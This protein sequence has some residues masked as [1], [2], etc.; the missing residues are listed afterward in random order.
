MANMRG[1]RRSRRHITEDPDDSDDEFWE[2]DQA[3]MA[4][5]D[6]KA[7]VENIKLQQNSCQK[8]SIV[9]HS[10]GTMN[11]LTAL[12]K[13]EYAQDYLAQVVLMEPCVVA[14]FDA[15]APLNFLSY[16]AVSNLLRA[17]NIESLFRPD[18]PA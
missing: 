3:E 2:F 10:L 13:A 9:A 1:S 5:G 14:Q 7:M 4:E 16:Y 11:T 17:L 12:T 18:W 8:V 6:I 15:Y